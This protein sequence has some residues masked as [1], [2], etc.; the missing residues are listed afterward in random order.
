M[1]YRPS[2]IDYMLSIAKITATM[3]TCSRL[4]VGAVV[5]DKAME[6]FAVGYNGGARGGLN[7]CR[8]PEAIG[9]CGC[10]HAEVNVIAKTDMTFPRIAFLTDSPCLLCAT[11]LINAHVEEVY[12][13]RSYR[14]QTGL[15]V[16]TESGIAFTQREP[17]SM[18]W[19]Y[20]AS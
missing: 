12:Y 6:R 8:F 2:K 1:R 5:S 13:I 7:H 16:L 19:R 4:Q 10:L 3:S 9:N 17:I 14:D 20:D 18:K 11:L 15:E